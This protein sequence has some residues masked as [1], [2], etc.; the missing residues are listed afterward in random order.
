MSTHAPCNVGP[1]GA[2]LATAGRPSRVAAVAEARCLA[3]STTTA[4]QKVQ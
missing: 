3:I 4:R 2:C 1:I